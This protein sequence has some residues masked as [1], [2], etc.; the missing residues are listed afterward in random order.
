MEKRAPLRLVQPAE[1]DAA[2]ALARSWYAGDALEHA[3][4]TAAI[5]A[6]DKVKTAE[7]GV[8]RA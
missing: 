7:N 3:L 2:V 8:S 1:A 4:A 6:A 5:V